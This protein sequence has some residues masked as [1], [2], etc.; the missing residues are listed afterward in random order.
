FDEMKRKGFARV[1]VNGVLH[2]LDEADDI[3]LERYEQ[4]DIEVV[5]DRVIVKSEARQRLAD[6]VQTALQLAEGVVMVEIVSPGSASEPPASEVLTFS[7]NFA[8]AACGISFEE[9]EP[10]TF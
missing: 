2:S 5:V 6:S 4:H 1:R 9:L 10:R 3:K 8:C 7:E